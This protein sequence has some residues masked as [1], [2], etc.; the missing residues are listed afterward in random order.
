MMDIGDRDDGRD[1]LVKWPFYFSALFIFV[2]ILGFAYL[3]FEKTGTLDQWQI[4]TC[5]L[6][7]GLASILVFLPYLID[8]FLFLVFDFFNGFHQE[9]FLVSFI[10]I[11]CTW[12]KKECRLKMYPKH[13]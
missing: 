2:L 11:P 1:G 13:F 12:S 8:R 9:V 3:H 4:V 5:I 6:G 7:S 10:D